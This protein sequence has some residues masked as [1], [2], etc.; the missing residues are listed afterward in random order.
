MRLNGICLRDDVVTHDL[1]EFAFV[2]WFCELD[3]SSFL[4]SNCTSPH[5]RRRAS[6]TMPSQEQEGGGGGQTAAPGVMR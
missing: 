4:K 5:A 1:V 6:I 3:K 2:F